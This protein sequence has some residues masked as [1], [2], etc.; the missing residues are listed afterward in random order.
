MALKVL[1]EPQSTSTNRCQ[2]LLESH[3]NSQGMWCSCCGFFIISQKG[4][5]RIHTLQPQPVGAIP[6]PFTVGCCM[7]CWNAVRTMS[8]WSKA[9]GCG[10]SLTSNHSAADASS[11]RQSSVHSLSLNLPEAVNAQLATQRRS[12]VPAE[13]GHATF[14]SM[15][16]TSLNS[17]FP[18]S[19]KQVFQAST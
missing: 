8:L 3:R 15:H 7:R 13:S 10:R 19:H 11:C 5:I 9:R 14:V 16:H 12:Q 1:S 18:A 4:P 17:M 2:N 6:L